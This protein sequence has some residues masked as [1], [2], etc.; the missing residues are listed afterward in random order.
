MMPPPFPFLNQVRAYNEVQHLMPTSLKKTA[1]AKSVT[2][3][4][5]RH[6][7]F[8]MQF[9]KIYSA[10]LNKV[11]RKGRAQQD[12]DKIIC[13]LTGH[14]PASLQKWIKGDA[15]LGAFFD[16]APAY[17]PAAKLITG[18]VCGVRVEE[19][20]E[21]SMRKVRQLDKLV[22]ELAQ[23]KALEKILRQ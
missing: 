18:T 9:T 15:D 22:D 21:P 14:T 4:A 5:P 10:L 17:N 8:A 7:I 13:W 23:G 20:A 3:A 12:L 2:A 16:Q 1:K 6:R 11:Q 19:V